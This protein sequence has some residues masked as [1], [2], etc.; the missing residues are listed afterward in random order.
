MKS[1]EAITKLEELH[2]QF[3]YD[4]NDSKTTAANH[5]VVQKI[6]LFLQALSDYRFHDL[7]HKKMYCQVLYR[8]STYYLHFTRDFQ[9][10]IEALTL[11]EELNLDTPMFSRD[12]LGDLYKDLAY[13]YQQKMQSEDSSLYEKKV[14]HYCNKVISQKES[15]STPCYQRKVAYAEIIIGHLARQKGRWA[16][17][18]DCYRSVLK[19][20]EE[21]GLTD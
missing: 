17:A 16:E 18:E 12:E 19:C 11:V 14:M 3:T 21:R 8:L 10:A 13:A 1:H 6:E 5:V 4:W 15:I 20:Y 2:A 9:K 7:L